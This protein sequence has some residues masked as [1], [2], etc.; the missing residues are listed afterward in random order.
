[1]WKR[2]LI[3][4]EKKTFRNNFNSLYALPLTKMKSVIT[5]DLPEGWIKK[6]EEKT[7]H[8]SNQ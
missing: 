5:Y 8:Y 4:I 7:Y 2:R 6:K 1:M 3:E